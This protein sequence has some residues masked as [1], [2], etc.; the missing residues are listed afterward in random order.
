MNTGKETVPVK[1]YMPKELAKLYDVTPKTLRTWLQPHQDAI[2]KRNGR[3]YTI[4]QVQIIFE[5]LGNPYYD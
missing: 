5:K 1:P 4:L 2:G 3:Y